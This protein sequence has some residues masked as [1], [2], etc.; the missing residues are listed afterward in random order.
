MKTKHN[1][2]PVCTYGFA[3]K[4]IVKS[5]VSSATSAVC[6][7]RIQQ[8]NKIINRRCKD[9]TFLTQRLSTVHGEDWT[10]I[11]QRSLDVK[12]DDDEPEQE[13]VKP[14]VV[15]VKEEKSDELCIDEKPRPAKK[16]TKRKSNR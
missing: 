6:F 3:I 14:M 15:K 13:N 5:E 8:I 9:V 11:P 10:V 12:T 4:S 16:P 2:L 1:H 7:C